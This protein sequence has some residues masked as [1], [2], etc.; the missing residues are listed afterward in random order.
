MNIQGTTLDEAKR[1]AAFDEVQVIMSR[2]APF[3]YLANQHNF[4]AIDN[5]VA[6]LKPTVLSSYRVTWNLE[7]LYF[8]KK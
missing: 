5:R 6:G 3:I 7:E 2:E 1:K 4:A 8:L